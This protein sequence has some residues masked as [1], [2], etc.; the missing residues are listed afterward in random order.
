MTRLDKTGTR[1]GASKCTFARCDF[2]W[3]VHLQGDPRRTWRLCRFR[4]PLTLRVWPLGFMGGIY[5]ALQGS[6]WASQLK[7]LHGDVFLFS[8][9]A[10]LGWLKSADPGMD[11]LPSRPTGNQCAGDRYSTRKIGNTSWYDWSY[12]IISSDDY[13]SIPKSQGWHIANDYTLVIQPVT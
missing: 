7:C 6:T 2:R 12:L 4:V 1:H 5:S 11:C 13:E 9:H 8:T 3:R 10:T